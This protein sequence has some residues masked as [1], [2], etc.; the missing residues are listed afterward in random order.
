MCHD[1]DDIASH[2]L[3]VITL[4]SVRATVTSQ[5]KR[6]N[7]VVRHKLS[8]I[9]CHVWLLSV[10]PWTSTTSEPEPPWSSKWMVVPSAPVATAMFERTIADQRA[11]GNGAFA[12]P[13]GAT[14]LGRW[15]SGRLVHTASARRAWRKYGVTRVGSGHGVDA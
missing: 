9:G 11:A 8:V 4:C 14:G 3:K 12:V 7:A 13:L 10:M 1:G 15:V 2:D 6:D 5:I